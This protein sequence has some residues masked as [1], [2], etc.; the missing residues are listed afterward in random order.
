MLGFLLV[1]GE[2]FRLVSQFFLARSDR[3]SGVM[4]S[5]RSLAISLAYLDLSA[6]VVFFHRLEASSEA[7]LLFLFATRAL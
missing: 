2:R 1:W 3:C 5:Q 7:A 6:A 4:F